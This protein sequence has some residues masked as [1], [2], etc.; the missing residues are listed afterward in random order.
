M[1]AIVGARNCAS[2]VLEPRGGILEEKSGGRLKIEDYDAMVLVGSP[3]VLLYQAVG[4]VADIIMK[5]IGYTATTVMN[6]NRDSDAA[7]LDDLCATLDP[8]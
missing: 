4:D 1:A 7:L 5:V 2:Q 6:M 3:S 8:E